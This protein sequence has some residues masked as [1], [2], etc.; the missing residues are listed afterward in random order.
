MIIINVAC[1]ER[2]LLNTPTINQFHANVPL[3]YP[4]EVVVFKGYRIKYLP[5]IGQID[6]WK[7][8]PF[9]VGL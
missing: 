4:H 7:E 6:F 1:A 5:E 8:I 2:I 9:L 3:L